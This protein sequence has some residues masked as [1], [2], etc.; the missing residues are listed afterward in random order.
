MFSFLSFSFWVG[1]VGKYSISVKLFVAVRRCFAFRFFGCE[2]NFK[3][4]ICFRNGSAIAYFFFGCAPPPAV[5]MCATYHT[6][7]YFRMGNIVTRIRFYSARYSH[8]FAKVHFCFWFGNS[9]FKG[10][11]FIFFYVNSVRFSTHLYAICTI[12]ATIWQYKFTGN[13]AK[14]IGFVLFA[15]NFL[16]ISIKKCGFVFNSSYCFLVI[17]IRVINYRFKVSCL[18]G[19]IKAA[20]GKNI[21]LCILIIATLISVE[22]RIGMA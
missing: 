11:S 9:Y 15:R 6:V 5:A 1:Y 12:Q 8:F 18:S 7:S 10:R 14:F 17:F 22:I 20:V 4:T 16:S 13:R 2:R 19:S 21:Y 3:C